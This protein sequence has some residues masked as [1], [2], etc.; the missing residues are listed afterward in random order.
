MHPRL[1]VWLQ[2]EAL[3]LLESLSPESLEKVIAQRLT[4]PAPGDDIF[5]R[6]RAV[7][8]LARN[9]RRLPELASV[10]PAVAGDPSPFVRQGLA[11][12]LEHAPLEV[13]SAW[14]RRCW[15]GRGDFILCGRTC[16][17][18]CSII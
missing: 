5:V 6:K 3:S 10:L 2:C 7:K 9:L 1:D 17:R 11:Q 15:R 16:R 12:S 4:R 8:L 18:W 14:L 13:R